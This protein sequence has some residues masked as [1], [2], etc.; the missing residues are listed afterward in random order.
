[1]ADIFRDSRANRQEPGSPEEPCSEELGYLQELWS[2]VVLP[3][4]GSQAEKTARGAQQ[5]GEREAEQVS[6]IGQRTLANTQVTKAAPALVRTCG[7]HPA[8]CRLSSKNGRSQIDRC[9]GGHQ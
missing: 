5:Q 6:V 9:P 2:D 8:R 1:M 7:W 4:N 3:D